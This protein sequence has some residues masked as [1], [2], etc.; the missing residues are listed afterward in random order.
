MKKCTKC[1]SELPLSGFSKRSRAKDGYKSQCKL[2]DSIEYDIAKSEGK[3]K[4]RGKSRHEEIFKAKHG[5]SAGTVRAYVMRE[6]GLL[7]G[8]VDDQTSMVAEYKR[9]RSRDRKT[10][11]TKGYKVRIK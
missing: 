10:V 5:V 1:G 8:E 3:I 9:F 2:C 4:L 6:Y 7:W 11:K